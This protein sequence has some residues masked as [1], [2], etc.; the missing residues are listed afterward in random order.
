LGGAAAARFVRSF[1]L[2]WRS[3]FHRLIGLEPLP[4]D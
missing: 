3:F 2:R 1:F 4:M